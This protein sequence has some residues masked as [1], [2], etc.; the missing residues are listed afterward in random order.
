MRIIS[1]IFML[2]LIF[3]NNVFCQE[4]VTTNQDGDEIRFTGSEENKVHV[5]TRDGVKVSYEIIFIE[6]KNNYMD[7]TMGI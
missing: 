2:F 3:Q 1:M 6:S 4:I 7:N 5:D